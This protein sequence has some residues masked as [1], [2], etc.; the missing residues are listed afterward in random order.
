MLWVVHCSRNVNLLL[1]VLW[2]VLDRPNSGRCEFGCWWR[3]Y[4]LSWLLLCIYLVYLLRVK[5][6]HLL[7]LNVVSCCPYSLLVKRYVVSFILR[8]D[9]IIMPIF[10]KLS[11]L[12]LISAGLPWSLAAINTVW[13]HFWLMLGRL[14][15]CK[16]YR[17][18]WSNLH[19][20]L[21]A[22]YT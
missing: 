15:V 10:C 8:G 22:F 21:Y 17:R 12:I 19:W 5:C 14:I 9:G 7:V 2:R 3:G 6:D 20:I 1:L 18:V 13:L 11:Q 16:L 4:S